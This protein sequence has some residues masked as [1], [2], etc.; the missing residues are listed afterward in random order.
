MGVLVIASND[1]EL[2][3]L[4]I[5]LQDLKPVQVHHLLRVEKVQRP[6]NNCLT[7]N[8]KSHPQKII[9]DQGLE[10]RQ[11]P[12]QQ[13]IHPVTERLNQKKLTILRYTPDSQ[14]NTTRSII[15]KETTKTK[16]R[17]KF[18]SNTKVNHRLLP[19]LPHQ[20]RSGTV[21]TLC[22]VTPTSL[23]KNCCGANS[24]TISPSLLTLILLICLPLSIKLFQKKKRNKKTFFF[25]RKKKVVFLYLNIT[26]RVFHHLVLNIQGSIWWGIQQISLLT[27][28]LLKGKS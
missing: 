14:L 5:E 1:V 7:W 8:T 28:I 18:A 2:P 15:T 27:V 22:S 4:Q 20:S 6:T 12:V 16:E 26:K 21:A 11:L 25:K 9:L 13:D 23:T 17:N 10:N 19:C 3:T 24:K